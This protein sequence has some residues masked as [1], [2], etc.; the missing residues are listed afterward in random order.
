MT[1]DELV[2]TYELISKVQKKYGCY[3]SFDYTLSEAKNGRRCPKWCFYTHDINH[4]Y[5]ST[6]VDL[7]VFLEKLLEKGFYYSRDLTRLKE[8]FADAIAK[9]KVWVEEKEEVEE[10]LRKEGA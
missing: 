10:L 4:N 6:V 3:I 1:N 2:L 8:R 7:N 5:F 9:I